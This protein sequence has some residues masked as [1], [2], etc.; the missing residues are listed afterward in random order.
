VSTGDFNQVIKNLD[1][2][3][4]YLYKPKAELLIHGDTNADYCIESN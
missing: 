1:G 4:K 3:L 2:A